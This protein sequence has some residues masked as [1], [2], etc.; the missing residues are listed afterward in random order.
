MD[1]SMDP[2]DLTWLSPACA[3]AKHPVGSRMS[4]GG[5]GSCRALG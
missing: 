4:P 2:G 3:L 5:T 1:A